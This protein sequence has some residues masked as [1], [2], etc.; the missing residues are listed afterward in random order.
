MFLKLG[1]RPP[2]LRNDQAQRILDDLEHAGYWGE[3]IDLSPS[4]T[5]ALERAAYGDTTEQI[6]Q[7][8]ALS[9]E[10]VKTYQARAR[11]KLGARNTTNAVAIAI[12]QDLIRSDTG[13]QEAA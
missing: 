1:W 8:M 4:E 12:T 2:P 5:R 9:F 7:E 3:T 13:W 6:A 11:L 10:T